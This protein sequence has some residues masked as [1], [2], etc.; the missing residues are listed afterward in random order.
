MRVRLKILLT[1]CIAAGG[2]GPSAASTFTPILSPSGRTKLT[3][4]IT[5][6]TDKTLNGCVAFEITVAKDNQRL[7][8]Q[9]RTSNTMK[10]EI[11]W[12]DDATI[13]LMSADI[14]SRAWRLTNGK[15]SP[16]PLPLPPELLPSDKQ[17]ATRYSSSRDRVRFPD[18]SIGNWVDLTEAQQSSLHLQ[19]SSFHAAHPLPEDGYVPVESTGPTLR[20]NVHN[21]TNDYV[22]EI[23]IRVRATDPTGAVLAEE[24]TATPGHY[25]MLPPT[26]SEPRT[27]VF[28][29]PH[30]KFANSEKWD[31]FELSVD[32]LAARFISPSQCIG[33]K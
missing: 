6:S 5:Q 7:H 2:S 29:S 24:V 21:S 10:W 9:T 15:V 18:S 12:H 32:V 3:P 4:S 16:L 23:R 20:A 1:L 11:R 28:D 22:A 19:R 31:I 25:Y 30:S 26:T 17:I 14:G 8:V 33:G 27:F 13:V